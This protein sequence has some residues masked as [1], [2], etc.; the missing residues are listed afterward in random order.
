MAGNSCKSIDFT[1]SPL[2]GTIMSQYML[3]ATTGTTM[4]QNMYCFCFANVSL[5]HV[6]K[7]RC[8]FPKIRSQLFQW[9]KWNTKEAQ[10]RHKHKSYFSQPHCKT[11]KYA[12]IYF[13]QKHTYQFYVSLMFGL[14]KVCDLFMSHF[15]LRSYLMCLIC[16]FVIFCVK[17]LKNHKTI[18]FL[19][20]IRS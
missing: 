5:M 18:Y 19:H 17:H 6:K 8:Y 1:C 16:Y 15:F 7:L 4:S 12:S 2:W 9:H 20:K 11:H 13:T 10:T 14:C 3:W